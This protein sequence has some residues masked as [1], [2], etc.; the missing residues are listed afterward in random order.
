MHRSATPDARRFVAVHRR[1]VLRMR[2]RTAAGRRRR[3]RLG[4][5]AAV[6]PRRSATRSLVIIPGEAAVTAFA[7]LGFST[8]QP[9]IAAVIAVAAAAA[10]AGDA[11][12]YLI[13]RR[14]GLERWRWMRA[15]RARAAFAWA[16]ARLDRSTAAIVF[17]A[18]FIP[19]A[20]LAVNLTAGRVAAFPRRATWRSARW[21]P[22]AGRRTSRSSGRWSPGFFPG[23]TDPRGARV[24]RGRARPRPRP[25]RDPRVGRIG[26]RR[27]RCEID[28]D[29]ARVRG[30]PVTDDPDR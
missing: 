21:R 25:R 23:S 19:F 18:R 24:D 8:G 28:P 4:P 14:V 5:A 10:F 6:P 13:G 3:E 29:R 9:P 7:A 17:T 15:R 30:R 26:E 22:P 16:R 20:R 1:L 27:I 12:C 11:L 2:D